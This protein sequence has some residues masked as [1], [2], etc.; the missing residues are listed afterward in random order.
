MKVVLVNNMLVHH[1]FFLAVAFNQCQTSIGEQVH[2]CY[3]AVHP[4]DKEDQKLGYSDFDGLLSEDVLRAYS[5][6]SE[7]KLCIEK[8]DEADMI[9]LG[10]SGEEL[11][12]NNDHA[13][14]F[15]M[16]ES[17]FRGNYKDLGRR[18]KFN[19]IISRAVKRKYYILALSAYL[20]DDI[21][22]CYPRIDE[23]TI[24]RWAYFSDGG[25]DNYYHK[26]VEPI[27]YGSSNNPIEMIWVG[28][29]QNWKH[30]EYAVYALEHVINKLGK[31][32][33][34]TI[35]GRSFDGYDKVLRRISDKLGVTDF[36]TYTGAVPFDKVYEY[37]SDSDIHLFTSNGQ[38]GWG[39]VLN[40]SMSRGCAVI[41]S[42]CAGA[43][44]FLLEDGINGLIYQNNDVSELCRK[45]TYLI[46]NPEEIV[47][48]GAR[49]RETICDVWN[50]ETAASNIIQLYES[51]ARGLKFAVQYGPAS[52]SCVIER[53]HLAFI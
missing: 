6:E 52:Q 17:F 8:L 39:A 15:K 5:S 29:I 43:T 36:I 47:K 1:M 45:L 25:I 40:E 34:L 49:A 10:D 50:A 26:K 27:D 3:I 4:V 23:S 16:M 24:Y 12:F 31:H 37:M 30:P 42:A 32:A 38:E 46:E 22:K 9:L 51:K 18:V 35:V 14:V 44:P 19:R 28:R 33:H 48:Y 2:C 13:V 21:K 11:A 7:Y 20:A 41:A 53:S